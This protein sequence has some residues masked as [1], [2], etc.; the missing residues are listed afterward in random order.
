MASRPGASRVRTHRAARATASTTTRRG[1]RVTAKWAATTTAT[2]VPCPPWNDAIVHHYVF[3]LYALD[4]ARLD[5]A[6]RFTGA[7]VVRAIQ[8]HVLAQATVTGRY[9]LNPAVKL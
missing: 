1:S 6:P 2:T 8:G 4:T 7:D 9:S 5:V 3:T